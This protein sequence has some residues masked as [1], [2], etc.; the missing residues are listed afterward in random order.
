MLRS[1]CITKAMI[2]EIHENILI[3]KTS[4]KCDMCKVGTLDYDRSKSIDSI[5]L[6]AFHECKNCGHS[7]YLEKTYPYLHYKERC[8]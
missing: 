7:V 4:L 3:K 2:N 6:E 5:P 1:G 8:N